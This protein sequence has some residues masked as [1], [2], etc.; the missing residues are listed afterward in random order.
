MLTFTT[1]DVLE[2]VKAVEAAFQHLDSEIASFQSWSLLGCKT[3]CGKCC[4]KPDI[5]A[6]ILEFLP[7]AQHL[8]EQDQAFEWLEKTKS[9]DSSLCVILN[10][11]HGGAGMCSQ[12]TYRGLICRLFGFSARTNKYARKELVTCQLIKEE[13][14]DKVR[15]ANEKID[16]GSGDVP[17]MNQ[18]YM[19]LHAIDFD[20]TREFFPINEAIKRAIEII[21]QYHAYRT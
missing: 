3:G 17:V 11:L 4:L 8:Y 15:V 21:L 5:E 10:P 7:F 14:A 20:L 2:K 6:T 9:A 16:A 13:L 1:V 18:H 19:R 12:Y